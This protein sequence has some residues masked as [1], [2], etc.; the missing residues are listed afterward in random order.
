MPPALDDVLQTIL[1]LVAG[2]VRERLA[3]ALT[4]RAV[5]RGCCGAADEMWLGL[6]LAPLDS[7]VD[8]G[9][10]DWTAG[11][12]QPEL[13]RLA[14]AIVQLSVAALLRVRR[15]TLAM[16][17][18][19]WTG[20]RDSLLARVHSTPLRTL[21][22]V[23]VQTTVGRSVHR[24]LF[25]P[26]RNALSRGRDARP[27]RAEPWCDRLAARV[28]CIVAASPVAVAPR[29]TMADAAKVRACTRLSMWMARGSARASGRR[30][31]PG[32]DP[33]SL[34]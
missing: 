23:M 30:E 6:V 27:D 4:V 28:S 29:D 20:A 7:A 24:P 25:R 9:A 26:L 10:A 22:G 14:A 33:A 18:G 21:F 11:L 3:T 1:L 15:H 12:P 8:R 5:S 13:E 34:P 32:T 17:P 16:D 2:T 31:A 19:L